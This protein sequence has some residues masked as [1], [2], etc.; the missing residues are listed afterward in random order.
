MRA[1]AA[2][3]LSAQ[4]GCAQLAY[5]P[6]ETGAQQGLLGHRYAGKTDRISTHR[7]SSDRSGGGTWWLHQVLWTVAMVAVVMVMLMVALVMAFDFVTSRG[8]PMLRG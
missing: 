7:G 1:C 5:Q 4:C 8:A 2:L 6:V 3:E